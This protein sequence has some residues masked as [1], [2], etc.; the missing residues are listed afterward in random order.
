MTAEQR[1]LAW[2][3]DAV[4]GLSLCPFAR[5]VRAE[6]RTVISDA[7]DFNAAVR[8][9]AEEAQRLIDDDTVPTTLIGFTDALGEFDDFLDALA[10][11]DHLLEESEGAEYVQVASFHPAY[12]FEGAARDALGNWTNRSPYPC[13]HLLRRDEVA[14]AIAAHPDTSGIPEANIA[15][16]EGLGADA[17]K[18]LWS[19]WALPDR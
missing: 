10:A 3:D 8:T 4:I 14:T 6:L 9:V 7:E 19:G 18:A 15:R 11:V 2:L 16:L 17:L 5:G 12:C 13:V 1:L